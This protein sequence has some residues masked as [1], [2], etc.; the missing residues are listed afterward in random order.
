MVETIREQEPEVKE[1]TKPVVKAEA[2]PEVKKEEQNLVTRVSQVKTPEKPAEEEH[3]NI[4]EL[5]AE[6]ERV[7]NPEVKKQLVSLKKSLIKGENQKYEQI[8]SLR[9]EYETKLAQSTS[10]TPER[11]KSEMNKPDFI[12]AAKA[13]VG[14]NGTID[15]DSTLSD[16]ARAELKQLKSKID[17]LQSSNWQAQK[18]HQDVK[19]KEKY[20]NYAP[21]IVD[22]VT[23][24]LMHNK[25]VATRED[26]WKVIDYDK[27]VNRAYELGLSDKI[28]INKE[29]AEGITAVDGSGSVTTSPALERKK[30]E[31]VQAFMVRSYQT[32]T[33]KK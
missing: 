16:E 8:A 26:L 14:G 2:K 31:S 25:R 9:K 1:E 21:D 17:M 19:L 20:A 22:T 18:A 15:E 32:H 23:T 24:D 11:V 5:D 10:W 3:F 6:I 7:D 30:G 12:E 29:K 13:V 27:A 4:N 33:T 28:I